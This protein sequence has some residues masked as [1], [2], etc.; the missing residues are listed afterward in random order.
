MA[1]AARNRKDNMTR[2]KGIMA[3]AAYSITIG[4]VAPM[5]SINRNQNIDKNDLRRR[6]E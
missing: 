2:W 5:S 1:I 3:S 6:T 4:L